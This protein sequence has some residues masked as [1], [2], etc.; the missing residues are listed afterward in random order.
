MSEYLGRDIVLMKTL[1]KVEEVAKEYGFDFKLCVE[2]K[3][4]NSHRG[5]DRYNIYYTNENK[6]RRN[7]IRISFLSTGAK[8]N[9]SR[10]YNGDKEYCKLSNENILLSFIQGLMRDLNDKENDNDRS[11]CRL[12]N[13]SRNRNSIIIN[14]NGNITADIKKLRDYN[15]NNMVSAFE[16]YKKEILE[17]KVYN[18]YLICLEHYTKLK[19]E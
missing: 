8:F 12:Y 1:N 19:G 5:I 11:V 2:N 17:S 10:N 4:N 13:Y 14:L 9:I 15:I 18:T 16:K 7:L 6:N 3:A